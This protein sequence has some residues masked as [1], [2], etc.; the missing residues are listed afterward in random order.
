MFEAFNNKLRLVLEDRGLRN[1]ILFVIGAL[2]LF[3]LGASVPIPGVNVLQ[4]ER[5]LNNNEFFGLLNIFSGGGLSN[6]SIMMLGVGPFITSSIIFQLLTLI[7]PR[8]KQLYHEE[9]VAGRRKVAQYSRLLTVPLCVIQ[10]LSLLVLLQKQGVLLPL[11]L[12]GQVT[13]I[14]V[15]TAG[16][17]LLMWIGELITEFGIGNGVSLLIF[18]GIVSRLPSILSQLWVTYDISQ[19]PMYLV[20]AVVG[21]VVLAAIVFVTEAERPIPVT[22]A[23]RVRGMK[24]YG[25]TST[26][27]PI[28]VNNA[29]V[30]PI[31]FAISIILFPQM[32]AGFL[33]SST[34]GTMQMVATAIKD[35]FNNQLIYGFLYFFLVVVFTYFYSAITFDPQAISENLQKNGA[36]IP[37]VRPG[38]STALY[39]SNILTRLT[40]IGALFLGIV[41]LLPIVIQNMTGIASLAIG[42]TSLLI[43]VSVAIEFVKQ[44]NAQISMREY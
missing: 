31:I 13:N 6:L 4:L 36:F 38:A 34:G 37:G 22:Y 44:I 16:S 1:R 39:V 35:F 30:M 24:M 21:L 7:F 20:F 41:A 18:A 27:L 26:Y 14:F 15:V 28:R 43:V 10:G 3:R 42:G 29:G 23:K 8:L 40:L 25:G 33:A 9:G 5:F 32:I 17:M 12:F 19:V 2:A 11:D